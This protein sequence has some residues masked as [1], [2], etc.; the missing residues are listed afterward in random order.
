MNAFEK[1][2]LSVT[3]F[4][5]AATGLVYFWMKHLLRSADPFSV[6]HHPWQ[7]RVLA[8]HVLLVPLLV[9]A[10]GL[11]AQDHIL[12][13]FL[14]DRAHRS[15]RSGIGAVVLA[16]PMVGS[17]YLLQVLT[18]PGPRRVLALIHAA[19]GA[20]FAILYVVHLV[21]SRSPRRATHGAGA[22]PGRRRPGGRRTSLP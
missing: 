12:A 16:L 10:L 21:L 7:P 14:D 15:R 2:L 8:S 9:F 13:H 6:V 1:G 20:A 18:G 19:S 11:I 22:R 3:T 4:A 17:G 5:A